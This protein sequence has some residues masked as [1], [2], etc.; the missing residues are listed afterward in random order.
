MEKVRRDN[1]WLFFALVFLGAAGLSSVVFGIEG[2]LRAVGGGVAGVPLVFAGMAAG[3]RVI[4]GFGAS[5]PAAGIAI[6]ANPP[7]CAIV[8]L[9]V[10]PFNQP[11]A[12]GGL[13][14]LATAFWSWFAVVNGSD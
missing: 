2:A 6:L 14:L 13:C 1:E 9:F 10:S 12:C 3:D 4:S 8:W 7:S 5:G 11:L